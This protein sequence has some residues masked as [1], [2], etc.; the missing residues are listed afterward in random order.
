LARPVHSPDV[1]TQ[2]IFG[3]SRPAATGHAFDVI[4]SP[5]VAFFRSSK[6]LFR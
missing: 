4:G 3:S 2:E 5:S 6:L 1:T